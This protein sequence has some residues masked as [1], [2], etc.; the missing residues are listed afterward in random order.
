MPNFSII[1]FK[2]SRGDEVVKEFIRKQ[3]KDSVAKISRL[4][5]LVG[6]HGP[7]LTMPYAR[8]M[9]DGLH[10]LRIR[11]RNEIRIFYICQVP[12]N[13]VV[14]LHAFKKRTQQTPVKEL[15]IA[16]QRHKDWTEI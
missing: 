16:K 7:L 8:S 2:N 4:I 3:D 1:F 15:K 11:G 6:E 13:I 12:G 14:V 10:E 5:D 9:G